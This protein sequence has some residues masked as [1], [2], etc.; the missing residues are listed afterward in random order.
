MSRQTAIRNTARP[1]YSAEERLRRDASPW[2]LVQGVLAP[3]QFL[4]FLISIALVARF[5]LTGQGQASATASILI[6]TAVLFTIMVTGSIWEKE[7]FGKYLFAPAFF[8]EDAVSMVV[9]ALHSA[10]VIGLLTGW[11]ETRQLMLLALAAYTS[12]A[13]NAA[14]FLFKLR[15]ARL[16]AAPRD[17]LR[18]D[19]L[20][21]YS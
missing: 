12:Y 5:L 20:N 17:A 14:Q 9:I 3:L 19:Q 8:W 18:M 16:Q 2:T 15:A 11:I 1:L 4:V 10:Y 21:S 6:K 7:V 13:L